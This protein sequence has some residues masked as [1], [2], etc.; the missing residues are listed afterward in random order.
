MAELKLRYSD[1]LRDALTTAATAN[2]R[3][4]NSEIISRL[5][6]SFDGHVSIRSPGDGGKKSYAPDFKQPKAEKKSR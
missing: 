1:E 5:E 2:H 4:L 3:S 6:E